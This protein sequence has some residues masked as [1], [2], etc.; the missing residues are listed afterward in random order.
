MPLI[1]SGF[2]TLL[3][4]AS[5]PKGSIYIT[6]L[7]GVWLEA[8]VEEPGEVLLQIYPSN[9]SCELQ[10]G[11]V[12]FFDGKISKNE[13]QRHIVEVFR[14]IPISGL[15]EIF[16][17]RVTGIGEV[18]KVNSDMLSLSCQGYACS[19]PSFLNVNANFPARKYAK[20]L[21]NVKPKTQLFF[22]GILENIGNDSVLEIRDSDFSFLKMST[23]GSQSS[24]PNKIWSTIKKEG[25]TK[26]TNLLRYG[27]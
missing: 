15:Q 3:E 23:V 18:T 16:P 5:Q 6:A 8:N 1:V 19:Q 12:Y 4:N 9:I 7:G 25:N 2:T 21:K 17:S 13:T 26:L 22:S 14:L 10:I 20:F 27:Y 11:M 24:S